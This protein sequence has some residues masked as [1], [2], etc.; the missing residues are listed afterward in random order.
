MFLQLID[1]ADPCSLLFLITL[2]LGI[3]VRFSGGDR[4]V[5][6]W[7]IRIAAFTFL[8]YAAH[9]MYS[10]L[11]LTTADWITLVIR[12][13]T[14]AGL[15]LGPAWIL[16][17][18]GAFASRQVVPALARLASRL[19]SARPSV[20]AHAQLTPVSADSSTADSESAAD[21]SAEQEEA[22]QK[23]AQANKRRSDARIACELLYNLYAPEIGARFPRDQFDDLVKR[24]LADEQS[25]DILEERAAQL[26]ATIQQHY[27]QVN[28]PEQFTDLNQ[29]AHWYAEQ[30]ERI[31]SLPVD[32]SYRENYLI[33]LNVRYDELTT[34]IL[35]ILGP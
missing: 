23:V 35:E 28:P 27:E 21:R 5:Q 34:R 32:Q 8:A 10:S 19:A 22:I 18:V 15:V 16:L 30:K 13:L 31:E 1:N 24:Y 29:L 2:L 14:A 4:N 9:A 6:I 17:A 7:G 25:P 20:T 33:Q 26:Q 11:P 12:S 3:G